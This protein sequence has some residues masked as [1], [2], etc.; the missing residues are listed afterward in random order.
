[1]PAETPGWYEGTIGIRL[2]A[3][4]LRKKDRIGQRNK[5]VKIF[6]AV[7]SKLSARAHRGRS[8][9]HADPPSPDARHIALHTC[10][11][12]HRFHSQRMSTEPSVDYKRETHTSTP[13]PNTG[14]RLDGGA[15]ERREEE[16]TP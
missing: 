6:S 8:H 5:I 11:A 14:L 4:L 13:E 9:G 15:D 7:N 10:T 2:S 16:P 1:M 12:E 3:H